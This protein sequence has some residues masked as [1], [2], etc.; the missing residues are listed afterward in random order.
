MK[1]KLLSLVLALALVCTGLMGCGD[2]SQEPQKEQPGGNDPTPSGQKT[3]LVLWMT[4]SDDGTEALNELVARF[5]ESSE[6]YHLTME[7]GGTVT[8]VRQKLKSMDKKYYPS[9][10]TA[11]PDMLYEYAAA[12]YIIPLQEFLDDDSEK[13]TEDIFDT[14]KRAY[15]D[16]DGNMVGG[17]LGISAK[18][19]MVNVDM[20]KEA[21]YML[22]DITSMEKVALIAQTAHEKG[23]C[24]YGYT[25]YNGNEITDIL[26]YQ[27]VDVLDADNGYGGAVSK[28]LYLD[29]DTNQA[30]TKLMELYAKL[31]QSGAYYYGAGGAGGVSLFANKQMLFWGCTNSFVYT[32]ENMNLGFEWAFV[33][34]V[35]VDE[36][37]EYKD[38]VLAEGTGFFITDKGNEEEQQGAYEVIKF[39]AQPENQSTWCTFRGYLP[40]TSE[41]AKDEAWL[42]WKEEVFP[43][44]EELMAKVI[45]TPDSL[46]LPYSQAM[47]SLN[48]ENNKLHANISSD[49]NGDL[50]AYIRQAAQNIDQN[51]ELLNLRGQ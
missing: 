2:S 5:N 32:L 45:N 49:P 41:A 18:G 16:Q 28:C 40:F 10:F 4:Y 27:G 42:A 9:L 35:G 17:I 19:W 38:C 29:G 8:E 34:Y 44:A 37:A 21:G 7:Y 13:W 36:D 30:L 14:V 23:L 11:A 15:S 6:K 48:D 26:T 39:F 47:K 46:A 31:G 12:D 33:P 20:L 51:I 3:E 25:P 43:S 1:Q 24:K 50:E 22:E